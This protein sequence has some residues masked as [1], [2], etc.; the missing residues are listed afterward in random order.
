MQRCREKIS[1]GQDE[2]GETLT[3]LT[4]FVAEQRAAN[5]RIIELLTAL[6]GQDPNSR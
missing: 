1:R 6:T 5:A 2:H 4:A 3:G